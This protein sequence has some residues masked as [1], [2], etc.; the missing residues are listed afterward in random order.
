MKWVYLLRHAAASFGNL[1]Q[2]DHTRPL[3]PKGR[4]EAYR[5]GRYMIDHQL[6]PDAVFCSESIRTRETWEFLNVEVNPVNVFFEKI[7]Y[8]ADA[9]SLLRYISLIPDKYQRILLIG[10]APGLADLTLNLATI[11]NNNDRDFFHH[12]GARFVTASMAIIESTASSWADLP[13]TPSQILNIISP[14]NLG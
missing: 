2:D 1:T 3:S 4:E 5:I 7:L 14:H 6:I 13:Y 9:R 12:V 10:H 8:L 11:R